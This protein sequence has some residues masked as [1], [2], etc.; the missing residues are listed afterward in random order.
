M[1]LS[2]E[3]ARQRLLSALKPLEIET[4][5]LAY[6]GGRTLGEDLTSQVDLPPFSN[7]SMDGF[8]VRADDLVQAGSESPVQLQVVGD[9]P[10]GVVSAGELQP[11][12][13]MRI[14]T[15]AQ[16]P[17]GADAVV[18]VEDTDFNIR[19]A[20][21][22]APPRVSVTRAVASGAYIRPQGEDLQR[23]DRVLSAGRRLRPQDLGMLATL[24]VAEVSVRRRPRVALLSTGDELL[25]V[26]F[27]LE[28]GKIRESNSYTLAAQVESSGGQPVHLGIVPDTA[29][30]VRESLENAV[31]RDVD[32]ILS[33]AGVSV[34]AFDFVRD[35]VEEHGE[36]DFWRVNM[37]PGKPF[38]FGH[39]RGIP[40]VGLPGNPVSAFVGFEVFL[41]PAILHMAGVEGWARR[42]V[43]VR[44]LEEVASDGRESYL[45]AVLG[46]EGHDLTARL[47]GH[48]GSGNLFSLVQATALV[49]IPSGV[50]A[51][52][53]GSLVD[54]WPLD[55]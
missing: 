25:P 48:Q 4:V 17:V 43:K 9:I 11:G 21:I 46:G 8:A 35:V 28:P 20:G 16:V 31:D 44:L 47:T 52:P 32:L 13:A 27:D 36:L 33:S 29:L 19:Q 18:P 12:Q 51:L 1:L 34:G 50:T 41:R 39:Y 5:P 42:T 38:S 55:W 40:F 53:S 2:V 23:G 7:S 26:D 15:G 3:E 49:V 22:G 6:A 24:G 37:R 14:M 30:A 10:A 45:R 54:A